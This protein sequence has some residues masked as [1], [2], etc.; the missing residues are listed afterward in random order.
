MVQFW[1][2]QPA[3]NGKYA[4]YSHSFAE[5]PP[6]SKQR[7]HNAQYAHYV[8]EGCI[9]L[10]QKALTGKAD[11]PSQLINCSLGADRV[12]PVDRIESMDNFYA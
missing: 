1:C 12:E 2:K 7:V 11:R 3:H 6:K 9:T 5:I 4:H 10:N 8:Q